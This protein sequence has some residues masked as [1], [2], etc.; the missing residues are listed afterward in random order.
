MNTIIDTH[1][2]YANFFGSEKLKPFIYLLS[3]KLSEGHVCLDLENAVEEMKGLQF[4]K[5]SAFEIPDLASEPLVGTNATEIKPFI[6]DETKLYIH[7]YYHYELNVVNSVTNLINAE[8]SVHA[9]RR[10]KLSAQQDLLKKLFFS[11]ADS[12]LSTDVNW[13]AISA[14]LGCLN[15][16][17]VLTGGPGTGKTT[18]I[19]KILAVLY[20]INPQ[21]K[22]ALAA[23]TGKAA[24]RMAESI[25]NVNLPVSDQIKELFKK[26]KPSTI[27][28]L[29]KN[30]SNSAQ[31]VHNEK[32][33]LIYDV[34]I[35]DESSMIDV[36]L[37]AKLLVAIGDN[38]RLFLLGDK[39]QLAS[40]EAG[41]LFGDL[42]MSL[43]NIN[44]FSKGKLDFI[45]SILPSEGCKLKEQYLSGGDHLLCDHIVELKYSHR[46]SSDKG[47]GKLSK[48]IINNEVD[49]LSSFFINNNDE[50]IVIDSTYSDE[51]FNKFIEGYQEYVDEK[52]MLIALQKLTKIR[53][54]C[55]VR[56][57]NSGLFFLN[58]RIEDHLHKKKVI[59]KSGEFYENRPIIVTKNNYALG[60]YN[61]DVGIIRYENKT[62]RA[63]FDDGQGGLKSVLPG[64][65]SHLDT[66]YAM[67]IHKSQGSEFNEVLVHL[68][69]DHSSLLT[70]E[71]LYTGITRAKSRAII[72]CGQ[73]VFLETCAAKVQRGSGVASR[74]SN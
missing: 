55:A 54:L 35:I 24:A 11:E 8:K 36:A 67:T 28:R 66:V 51:L 26:I 65:I 37:F 69:K 31:F 27:H 25:N 18:T 64:Y 48:A 39:D 43:E 3:K 49:D 68:P 9:D 13:Q 19:S 29:L 33:K 70:R 61:G 72:Q 7:R 41:S 45:N 21:L 47:I 16:F 50:Q 42:C 63:W 20:S 23:P 22:V 59:V 57:G 58:K 56:D 38:T 44:T 17:T 53:V 12:K 60:L 14:I 46:F 73:D 30:K 71:L 74:I 32:N 4:V 40:V 10:D 1:L 34:V 62:A 5:N 2:Q 15:N 52:D 6:L